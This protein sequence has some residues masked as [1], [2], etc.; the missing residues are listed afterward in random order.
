MPQDVRVLCPICSGADCA[1]F[2]GY[3]GRE[4]VAEK[5]TH[6]KAFPIARFECHGKGNI[7]PGAH[8]TFSLLPYQLIPYVK[9][10]LPFIIKN[11]SFVYGEGESVKQLLDHLAESKEGHMDLSP[12]SFYRFRTFILHC[13][14]KMLA[15][16]TYSEAAELF[17]MPETGRTKAFIGFAQGFICCK[18]YHPIRG[19]CALGYDFYLTSGGYFLFGTPSQHR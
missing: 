10:S 5:G 12:S 13:I 18:L 9:Y 15:A 14:D 4:A 7:P 6:F 17:Q 8:R 16:G 3:Y 1:E 19:P 11:L 2:I